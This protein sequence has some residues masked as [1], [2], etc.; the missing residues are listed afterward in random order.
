MLEIKDVTKSDMWLNGGYFVFRREI[1]DYIRE[2]E[3]LVENLSSG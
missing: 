1:F 2:G 3:D